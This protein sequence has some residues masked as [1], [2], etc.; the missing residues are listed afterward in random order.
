[1][2]SSLGYL[3]ACLLQHSIPPP[4]DGNTESPIILP[5]STIP[6]KGILV[7]GHSFFLFFFLVKICFIG[8]SNHL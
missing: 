5:L 2:A 4:S 7:K 1:M 8:V 3:T 6:E